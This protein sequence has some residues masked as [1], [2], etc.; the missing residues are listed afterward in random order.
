MSKEGVSRRNMYFDGRSKLKKR[1]CGREVY[2]EEVCMLKGGVSQRNMY[3]KRRC[4][5]KKHVNVQGR[6]KLKVRGA[7]AHRT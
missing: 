4:M 5:S 6:C 2:V 7:S 3:V 1:V